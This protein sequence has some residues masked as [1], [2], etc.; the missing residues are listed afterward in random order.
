MLAKMPRAEVLKT[1]FEIGELVNN[2]KADYNDAVYAE[3]VA[4]VQDVFN[5]KL[6]PLQPGEAITVL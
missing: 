4:V 3:L 2:I 1:L 6:S 5:T